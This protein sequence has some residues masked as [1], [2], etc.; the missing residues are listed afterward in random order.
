MRRLLSLPSAL[1]RCRSCP[2]TLA[3]SSITGTHG[4][5]FGSLPEHRHELNATEQPKG[6]EELLAVLGRLGRQGLHAQL[7]WEV[8]RAQQAGT[9]DRRHY[10]AAVRSTLEPPP[11]PH[12]QPDPHSPPPPLQI[13]G[14]VSLGAPHEEAL[15]LLPR[16]GADGIEPNRTSYTVQLLRLSPE[17]KP[18]PEE[19]EP[20]PEPEPADAEPEP[21]PEPEPAS[22]GAVRARQRRALGGGGAASDGDGGRR[23]RARVRRLHPR[24][25]RARTARGMAHRARTFGLAGRAAGGS[26]THARAPPRPWQLAGAALQ[27][28]REMT[29]RGI[30]PDLVSSVASLR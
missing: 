3:R 8:D 11:Q 16:M 20:E 27:L 14:L 18:E 23:L 15:R 17:P 13:R 19:P 21:E 4:R 30:S 28:L 9:M 25:R 26:A 24:H 1:P 22:G 10:N 5:H 6:P 7:L 29:S 12:L 2:T